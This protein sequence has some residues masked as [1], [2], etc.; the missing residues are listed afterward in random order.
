MRNYG[1]SDAS[2]Y[3]AGEPGAKPLEREPAKTGTR[4]YTPG[5]RLLASRSDPYFRGFDQKMPDYWRMLEW[6]REFDAADAA[7]TVPALTLLR[8]SHDHFGDFKDAIDGVNTVE[9]EMA[10]NDYAIGR[11]IERIAASKVADS[12]VVFIIEDDAQNGA[13]HVDARRSI[14]FVVGAHVTQQALVSTRYTTVSLLR[15]IEALLGLKPLGLNDALALPMA[16]VFDMAATPWSY[17]AT[18]A[19]VLKTTALPIPDDRYAVATRACPTHT[20]QYWADAMRGQNF[21]QEDR[22]DT[23]AFNTA[24]WR[25]LGSGPE[26]VVRSGADLRQGRTATVAAAS[27]S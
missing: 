26:P 3:D 1:F 22:L 10:D 18:A 23:A 24:L 19:S 6:Q 8:L 13:D 12:T 25:G 20:A 14:A 15:T 5:D 4:I 16:D 11:V 9:T 2:I 17:R 7:G 21:A 27:C